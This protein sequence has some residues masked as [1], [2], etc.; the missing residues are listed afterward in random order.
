MGLKI[1]LIPAFYGESIL[2]SFSDLNSKVR[3]ILIDGGIPRTYPKYLKSRLKEIISNKENI[4]LL[5]VT[6]IDSDHI[7]GIL[8]LFKDRYF[9]KS[10]IKKVWFNSEK[11]IAKKYKSIIDNPDDIILD[12][13]VNKQSSAVQAIKL[14]DKLQELHCWDDEIVQVND[15]FVNL[16][17]YGVKLTILSPNFD[18]LTEKLIKEKKKNKFTASNVN[19]YHKSIK[20]L[21]EKDFDEDKS[22]TNRSSI[23]FILEDTDSRKYLFLG[24]SHPKDIIIALGNLGYCENNKLKLE[25]MKVSHHA[26]SG[27]TNEELLKMIDCNKFIICTDGTHNGHPSK[28]CLSRI[29][30]CCD[31][32]EFYFNYDV[33]KNIFSD[34]ELK[35]NKIICYLKK[36]IEV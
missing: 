18:C 10:F 21:L 7:G 16:D 28:E 5:I 26:S 23:A 20:E 36:F 22:S 31:Y 11:N 35:S 13:T 34:N 33:Y 30:K 1:E 19:D 9:D 32:V 3:N 14:E 27:N 4:D 2:V 6:H 12:D 25:Y 8:N 17:L 24:D 29:I 15:K